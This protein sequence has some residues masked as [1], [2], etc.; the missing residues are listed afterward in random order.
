MEFNKETFKKALKTNKIVRHQQHFEQVV[1]SY[2]EIENQDLHTD[3][4]GRSEQLK[5]FV[6]EFIEAWEDGNA[7]DSD[8]YRKAK[9]F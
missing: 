9:S 4:V 5:A 2:L 3:D 8:L 7:G 1:K 6:D